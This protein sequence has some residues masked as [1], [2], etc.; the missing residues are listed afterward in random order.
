MDIPE[1]QKPEFFIKIYTTD[2]IEK[3]Q[4]IRD[5]HRTLHTFSVDEWRFFFRCHKTFTSNVTSSFIDSLETVEIF[6]RDP[7][8]T[9]EQ[10]KLEK[11]VNTYLLAH[12]RMTV[13]KHLESLL[14]KVS[15]LF[16]V[17]LSEALSPDVLSN[18]L[19]ALLGSRTDLS[20]VFGL[21]SLAPTDVDLNEVFGQ[22][23]ARS[24]NSSVEHLQSRFLTACNELHRLGLLANSKKRKAASSYVKKTF[25]SKSTPF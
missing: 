15:E 10:L 18:T 13:Y 20:I 17:E 23:V 24:Q 16:V 1:Q 22:F 6:Q 25:Y 19:S 7:I 14:N 11:C 9:L 5:F 3:L 8:K 21:L 12:I 4:E 2:E